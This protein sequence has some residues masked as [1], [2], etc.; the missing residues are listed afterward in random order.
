MT[1]EVLSEMMLQS[2]EA[3]AAF[4][5]FEDNDYKIKLLEK[6]ITVKMTL[7]AELKERREHV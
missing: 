4:N 6:A 2:L 5:Q 7:L 1:S 3:S